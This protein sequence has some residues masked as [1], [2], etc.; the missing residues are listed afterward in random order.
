[1]PGRQ[2][3]RSPR[4]SRPARPAPSSVI[5]A[6]LARIAERDHVAQCLHGRHR[7]SARAPRRA[8]STRIARAGRPLGPLAGVPFAVKNLFDVAGLPTLAGS[9]INRDRPPAAADATLIA[10]LEAAG[11]VLVGALNMGEYAYDFTGENVHDGPSR[12]PHDTGAHDRRLVR[13]LGRRGRRRAGAARARLRHQRLDPRAV[14]VLRPVR[15]Q[16]DLRPPVARPHVP[17]RGEPRSP[18]PAGA[19]RRGPG[20][21]LRRHAGRTTPTI[22]CARRG[23]SSRCCPASS[24]APAACASRLPAAI[25]ARRLARGACRRRSRRQGARMRRARSRFPRPA[26]A[27]AAAY[28]ITAT[29]GAALHLDRLRTRARRL[30]SRPCATG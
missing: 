7:A 4:P 29:E 16:A 1:M 27:R 24:A 11:A 26:R 18:G 6:A 22:R 14:V 21:R 25:S 8:R 12:N 30:R 9:K 10:R 23:R 17:V 13:R 5:E 2:P 19:L 20:A 15:P 3:P 28:V